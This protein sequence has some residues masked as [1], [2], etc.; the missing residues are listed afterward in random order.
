MQYHLSLHSYCVYVIILNM[1]MQ[2]QMFLSVTDM[3]WTLFVAKTP[4]LMTV[5]VHSG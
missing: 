4:S 1:F 3:L 5:C 2:I